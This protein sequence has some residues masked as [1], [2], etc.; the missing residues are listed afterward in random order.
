MLTSIHVAVL[1]MGYIE[2]I[3]EFLS[4]GGIAE[5]GLSGAAHVRFGY[6]VVRSTQSKNLIW[7]DEYHPQCR[8]VSPCIFSSTHG[9]SIFLHSRYN[10]VRTELCLSD[11]RY[12]VLVQQP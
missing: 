6:C 12:V 2:G 10:I 7:D 11:V 1:L 3:L 9:H 8:H 5:E 4:I